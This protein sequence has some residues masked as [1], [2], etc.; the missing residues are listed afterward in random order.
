MT[1]MNKLSKIVS[2]LLAM[3]LL[4]TPV[5]SLAEDFEDP[6][7]WAETWPSGITCIRKQRNFSLNS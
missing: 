1:K 5:F 6:E 7:T 4:L 2:L 3:L